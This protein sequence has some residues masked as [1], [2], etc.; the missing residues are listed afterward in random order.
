MRINVCPTCGS[1]KIKKVQR[2]WKGD[3]HGKTYQVPSL[4][5]YECPE[6][7]EKIYDRMAMRKIESHSPAFENR[8]RNEFEE[9]L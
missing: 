7:G 2:A 8:Y 3:F 6:C 1:D 4:E 9:A 5:F